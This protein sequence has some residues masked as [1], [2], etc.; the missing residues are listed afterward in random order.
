MQALV[1]AP[2]ELVTTPAVNALTNYVPAIILKLLRPAPCVAGLPASVRSG[3]RM[4]SSSEDPCGTHSLTTNQKRLRT[5]AT[6]LYQDFDALRWPVFVAD[7]E[8]RR[9]LVERWLHLAHHC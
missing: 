2:D 1:A 4:E 9:R 8:G 5:L 3:S 7:H 6:D